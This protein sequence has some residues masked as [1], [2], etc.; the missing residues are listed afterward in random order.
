MKCVI[1]ITL[2]LD[3]ELGSESKTVEGIQREQ[4]LLDD[5]VLYMQENQY[6]DGC[7]K[8]EKRCIR[9]KAK[10]FVL[11]GGDLLY[12]KKDKTKVCQLI[13]ISMHIHTIRTYIAYSYMHTMHTH[14]HIS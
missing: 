8:N 6:R 9:R 10:K 13:A 7:T 1:S 2:M 11:Q 4:Q 14:A 3:S 5:A 12:I